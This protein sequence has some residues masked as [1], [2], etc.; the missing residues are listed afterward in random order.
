MLKRIKI[1]TIYSSCLFNV[2]LMAIFW[3]GLQII[4][5]HV[6]TIFYRLSHLGDSNNNRAEAENHVTC[7]S[8]A[9]VYTFTRLSYF[10]TLTII[11]AIFRGAGTRNHRLQYFKCNCFYS[12]PLNTCVDL[13][14]AELYRAVVV[15]QSL[16]MN[17]H[18]FATPGNENIEQ[19]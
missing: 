16:P 11:T 5:E 4:R 9:M 14:M 19:N 3:N 17:N 2:F 10:M 15:S 12:L 1:L 7:E 8:R 13:A 6:C 18:F